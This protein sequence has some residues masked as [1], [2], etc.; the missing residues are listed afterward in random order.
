MS[1]EVEEAGYVIKKWGNI[2]PNLVTRIVR[3][4]PDL[5]EVAEEVAFYPIEYGLFFNVLLPERNKVCERACESAYTVHLWN[6]FYRS[7]AIPKNMLPPAGSF[8]HTKF[9][10]LLGEDFAPAF[11]AEA[12]RMLINGNLVFR[13]LQ[14]RKRIKRA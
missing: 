14:K 10:D 8:L 13:D 1:R 2:G 12:V 4:Y 9:V 11:P 3:E 5:T 6:Q 7:N